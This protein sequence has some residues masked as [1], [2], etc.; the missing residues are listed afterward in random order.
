MAIAPPILALAV[1]GYIPRVGARA[2]RSGR[3]MRT[4]LA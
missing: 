4:S 1:I 3:T 2:R